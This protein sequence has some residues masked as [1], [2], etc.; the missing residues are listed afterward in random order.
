ML[1][2]TFIMASLCKL[3]E[4]LIEGDYFLSFDDFLEM[5]RD[6]SVKHKFSFRTLYKDPKRA[7][8]RYTNKEY[9]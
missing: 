8:Y 3:R 5:I 4:L 6:V 2:S 9:S 1:P 7:R